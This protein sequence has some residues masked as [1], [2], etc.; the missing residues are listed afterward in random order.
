[1]CAKGPGGDIISRESSTEGEIRFSSGLIL[2]GGGQVMQASVSLPGGAML[3]IVEAT[4]AV[5]AHTTWSYP[6]LHGDVIITT[7]DAGVRIG[8][9][10]SF[11]PFGQPIDPVTGRIGT[12]D[13][14]DAVGDT[15][16]GSSADWAWV[17]GHRK[18]YEHQGSIAT[19]EMGARQY[20]AVLGRFLEVDPVEGGVT[21][22]YDY[23]ADPINMFDLT[24]NASKAGLK[25]SNW[26][27]CMACAKVGQR[28]KRLGEA[29]SRFFSGVGEL[30]RFAYNAAPSS[31]G[32]LVAIVAGAKDCGWGKGGLVVCGGANFN[33]GGGGTTFGNVFV[34]TDSLANVRGDEHLMD[35]ELGHSSQWAWLG[36]SGFVAA[37]S[38][39]TTT[40]Y[41]LANHY[42][43]ASPMERFDSHYDDICDG[44]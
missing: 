10:A 20:V 3:N 13:A 23:P 15:I 17:G 19:I 11:D 12:L 2:D 36:G 1:M 9:R 14:D 18:L 43:C 34:T 6:N 5:P 24:G 26:P 31:L 39:S 7:D 16:E 22:A 44:S 32:G 25:K 33:V 40:S 37:Y 27:D 8:A 4:G 30:G 28:A 35:H 41:I 29:F 21:N 38:A 42:G